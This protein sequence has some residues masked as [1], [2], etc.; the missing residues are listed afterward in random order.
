MI[1]G[2][3]DVLNDGRMR[4]RFHAEPME[5]NGTP[6]L[7]EAF[8]AVAL[9]YQLHPDL[10]LILSHTGMINATNARHLLTTYPNVVMTGLPGAG[11]SATIKALALR[12]MPYGVRTFVAG[13]LKKEYAALRQ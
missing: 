13:G 6:H 7:A 12:L 10:K 3:A 11:K 4:E 9:W 1:L 8:G 2:L 5:P